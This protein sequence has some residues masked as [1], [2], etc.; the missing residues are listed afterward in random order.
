MTLLPKST[1]FL[2]TFPD[3]AAGCGLLNEIAD[4][5]TG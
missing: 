3:P 1:L 4:E 5:I 2:Y